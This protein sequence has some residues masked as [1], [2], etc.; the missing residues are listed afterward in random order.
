MPPRQ[1]SAP[2]R[3]LEAVSVLSLIVT[4]VASLVVYV[5][6]ISVSLITTKAFVLVAGT[7]VTLVLYIFVRLMRGNII[8]PPLTLLGALWL[9]IIAYVLSSVFSGTPFTQALW[10]TALEPDTLGFMLAAAS[11][12][13]LSALILRRPEQYR[14]FL[15]A[16]AYTLGAIIAL[17]LLIIVVGQFAPNVISPSLS[18]V[19]S[20]E[21]LASLLGLGVI[22]ILIT[23]RFLDLEKR[24]YRSLVILGAASLALL[25]ITNA[26]LVW[27]LLALVSLGLFVESTMHRKSQ[28]SDSDL[29]E[30]LPLGES[31]T[32]DSS[33]ETDD[34]NHS[35][36][37]PL[38]VLAV[39]LFFLIG[40]AFGTAI[41]NTLHINVFNVRPSWQST[42]TV[43]QQT[44]KTAPVFGS[45]PGTFGIEWLRYRDSSLNSTI[46]W[47]IDF[48]TGIGFIPTSFV[49]TGIF[50]AL[51]WLAFFGLLVTIGLR[52]LILRA[53]K[54][55]FTRYVAAISFIGAVYFLIM[56]IFTV[57]SAVV[58][59]LA[60]V[61][62]GL[63]V[64]TM[65][66]ADGEAQWGV[67]FSRS[68]RI[69]FVIVF[70]LTI[71][72]LSSVVV[73]YTLVG[74]YV[75]TVELANS[76]SAFSAGDLDKASKSAQN[77]ISFAPS[78]MAY[79]V[80]AT[81]ANT[82]LT[83]IVTSTT[84]DPK[85]A[86]QSYQTELSAGIVAAQAATKISP[87]NYQSWLALGNLYAQTVPFGI[88][89]GYDNASDAYTKAMDLNPTNPQ[90]PYIMA[91]LDIAHKDSKAAQANLIKA[92]TLKQDYTAAIFLLS[93]L[94]VQDGNVKDALASSL[95]AAYFSPNNPNILF[96]IGILY[97]AQN[98]LANAAAALS[99]AINANQQ[100]AN[101]RY[102]LSAVYAKQ[103]DMKN[104]IAQMQAISAVSS[105]NATA[106][107]SQLTALKDGKNPFPAN[108]LTITSTPV[109]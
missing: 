70:C 50:G 47:N 100:F 18:I 29:E 88:T 58:L 52:T 68:P 40:G 55:A 33:F 23:I 102:F 51:A 75:A 104:A 85:V 91:Q 10:G 54:D 44:Y 103:G 95:A 97:A 84:L 45:G 9:P 6:F 2:R 36:V 86:Q 43:A 73:A 78:F 99:A 35:L 38:A 37:L 3:S 26:T 101:A 83:T 69:G 27:I 109:Q 89:G 8:L 16:G 14:T 41:A 34:G 39:S 15:R 30:S 87:S 21:D 61:F 46:F 60:F 28:S 4:L 31:S 64:S 93:Q 63:F 17:E 42:L 72:L 59:A 67:I 19:G 90:I 12:G 32:S 107:A 66:F 25:V 49:T 92:I 79:Q 98:D 106:V 77:S 96:Q 71:L 22:L 108:L 48:P 5:P 11:I 62:I 13:T 24:N 65:R 56:A 57:P 82:R 74:R 81:I 53:S 94:Q 20:F 76:T 105:E 80:Q 1:E 7:L